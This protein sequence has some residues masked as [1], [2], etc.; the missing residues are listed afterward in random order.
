MSCHSKYQTELSSLG[1]LES[2]LNSM[3]LG[4]VSKNETLSQSF[5]RSKILFQKN[6]IKMRSGLRMLSSTWKLNTFFSFLSLSSSLTL[7][8]FYWLFLLLLFSPFSLFHYSQSLK[9]VELTN[10]VPLI[11]NKYYCFDP[12]TWWHGRRRMF[13]KLFVLLDE[14]KLVWVW[15]LMKCLEVFFPHPSVSSPSGRSYF[16]YIELVMF[17]GLLYLFFI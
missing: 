3:F 4:W 1:C 17:Y 9:R 13:E 16:M 10:V 14:R 6:K 12:E 2:I 5:M 7:S 8:I 11:V 15:F